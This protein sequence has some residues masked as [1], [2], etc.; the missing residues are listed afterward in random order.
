[1]ETYIDRKSN[2]VKKLEIKE[3]VDF[4]KI[5]NEIKNPYSFCYICL[6]NNPL[7][8]CF[9]VDQIELL[10]NLNKRCLFIIDE[11]Y[12]EYSPK[13]SLTSLIK[14]YKNIVITRTFSKA[15]GLILYLQI[16]KCFIT[17]TI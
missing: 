14:N 4:Y 9:T 8:Y 16:L 6:P 11:A 12:Y 13:H 10:L 15:F 1:M 3:Y 7:G 17:T 2:N 5:V